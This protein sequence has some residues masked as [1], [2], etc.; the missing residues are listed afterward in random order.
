VETRGDFGK[1]IMMIIVN[2]EL[3]KQGKAQRLG[4]NSEVA[5]AAGESIKPALEKLDRHYEK[6]ERVLQSGAVQAT[7]RVKM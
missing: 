5:K 4:G 3:L 2:D 6:L 1:K 7:V